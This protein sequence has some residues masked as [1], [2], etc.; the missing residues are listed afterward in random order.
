MIRT[1][2][3]P[4]VG[5][6]SGKAIREDPWRP[7]YLQEAGLFHS[8]LG[9]F[10]YA[11]LC[12]VE[13]EEAAL[14]TLAAQTD[15][16]EIGAAR[17]TAQK[18]TEISALLAKRGIVAD[19]QKAGSD[20]VTELSAAICAKQATETTTDREAVLADLMKG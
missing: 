13:G 1:F 8:S 4:M 9:N 5:P 6:A 12:K 7:K 16:I 10:R 20:L 17:L 14:D 11:M 15:V 18:E 2:I 3:V 19:M